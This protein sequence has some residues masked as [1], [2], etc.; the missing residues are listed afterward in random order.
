[1]R[2]LLPMSQRF[3]LCWGF[4]VLQGLLACVGIELPTQALAKHLTP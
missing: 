4:R 2:C 1:M 3:M